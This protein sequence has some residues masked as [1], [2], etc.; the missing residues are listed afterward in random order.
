MDDA[1]RLWLERLH[2]A[3][4][5]AMDD[6][7]GAHDPVLEALGADLNKLAA[8]LRR[9]LDGAVHGELDPPGIC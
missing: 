6:V 5:R 8:R 3:T 9:E 2:T 4:R 1:R 7:A